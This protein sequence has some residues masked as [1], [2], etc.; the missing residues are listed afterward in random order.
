MAYPPENAMAICLSIY[1][2]FLE[3]IRLDNQKKKIEDI[4]DQ[5][6]D[7][8]VSIEQDL[9]LRDALCNLKISVTNDGQMNHVKFIVAGS[10]FDSFQIPNDA[11]VNVPSFNKKYGGNLDPMINHVTRLLQ[12]G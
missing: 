8:V 5:L 12:N 3:R 4:K 2:L 1:S 7:R 10:E 9:F 6:T 11:E